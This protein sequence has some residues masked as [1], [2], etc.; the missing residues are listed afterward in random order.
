[1]TDIVEQLR[2]LQSGAAWVCGETA[3]TL[4]DAADE[5]ERLRAA[6]SVA[7]LDARRF[8]RERDKAE[9]LRDLAREVCNLAI[10]EMADM[11]RQAG[12][13]RG[14]AEGKDI[15]IRQLEAE[16]DRLRDAVQW[17]IDNDET[18]EGDTPL[19]EYGGRCWN[20]INAYWIAGL[21][22]ARAALKETGQ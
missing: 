14:I 21:N 8:H 10:K 3:A 5:I 17:F 12:S 2:L 13:W 18:N 11:A 16:R 20:E 19:P 1:M 22:R 6:E 7:L 9:A 4:E 15:V